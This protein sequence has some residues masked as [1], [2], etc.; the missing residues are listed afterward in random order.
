MPGRQPPP[1]FRTAVPGVPLVCRTRQEPIQ[2]RHGLPLRGR[3]HVGVHI[4]CDYDRRAHELGGHELEIAGVLQQSGGMRIA[5]IV[6]AGGLGQTRCHESVLNRR[7]T[8]LCSSSGFPSWLA[9]TGSVGALNGDQRWCAE[10][11]PGH[12]ILS[13]TRASSDRRCRSSWSRPGS[14]RGSRPTRAS[15]RSPG[16]AGEPRR[17][18]AAAARPARLHLTTRTRP[19]GPRARCRGRAPRGPGRVRSRSARPG[20]GRPRRGRTARSGP[21]RR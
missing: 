8:V 16:P 17:P 6:E 13:T 2:L 11:P 3:L 9:K 10:E 1:T 21:A 12:R 5:K 15:R 18:P 7:R 20:G 19:G 14:T 4:R